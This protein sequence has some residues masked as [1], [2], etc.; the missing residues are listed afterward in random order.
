MGMP[1]AIPGCSGCPGCSC[2]A[3]GTVPGVGGSCA[4]EGE[5]AARR[6]VPTGVAAAR[7]E[8]EAAAAGRAAAAACG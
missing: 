6:A 7:G 8:G 1:G 4:G 2:T 3:T 5:L